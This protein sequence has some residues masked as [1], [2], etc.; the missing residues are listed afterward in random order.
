MSAFPTSV[1][2]L[3]GF[4]TYAGSTNITAPDPLGGP[5]IT[6]LGGYGFTPG[7]G[8][9]ASVSFNVDLFF[10]G[11]VATSNGNSFV[12]LD[13]FEGYFNDSEPLDLIL[14][15]I[16]GFFS[17]DNGEVFFGAYY[18]VGA[19]TSATSAGVFSIGNGLLPET[20][21]SA[22]DEIGRAHV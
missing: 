21:L 18:L 15:E 19:Q 20:R 12:Q 9:G 3:V 5:A 7:P 6:T 10:D 13:I 8:G 11:V 22:S 2:N 17:G 16:D 4:S 1:V 14:S